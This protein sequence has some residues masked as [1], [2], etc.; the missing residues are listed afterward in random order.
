MCVV[1]C[2][3]N[4]AST[5]FFDLCVSPFIVHLRQFGSVGSLAEGSTLR[6][7][8]SIPGYIQKGG[9]AYMMR[10]LPQTFTPYSFEGRC[11]ITHSSHGVDQQHIGASDLGGL[12][13]DMGTVL[14]I[15]PCN[16]PC[17]GVTQPHL[18]IFR[19]ISVYPFTPSAHTGKPKSHQCSSSIKPKMM[20]PSG[21]IGGCGP[22][23]SSDSG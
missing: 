12:Y 17:Q 21:G 20:P 14:I 9:W 7:F 6:D 3:T 8:Y 5:L 13:E 4:S 10:F 1:F 19:K 23:R 22:L 2:R 15:H 16:H 11:C 18:A